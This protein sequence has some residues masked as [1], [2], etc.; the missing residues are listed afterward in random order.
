MT[1]HPI[2][3]PTACCDVTSVVRPINRISLSISSYILGPS[4]ALLLGSFCPS[5]WCQASQLIISSFVHARSSRDSLSIAKEQLLHILTHHQAMPEFIDHVFTFCRRETPHLQT[6]FSVDDHLG[7][8]QPT[9]RIDELGRSGLLAQHCFNLVGIEKETSKDPNWPYFLRQTA[10]YQ[11]FD[12]IGG[13][14]FW[15]I[16]K[17]NQ[18][19]RDRI[20]KEAD[21]RKRRHCRGK[22]E[23]AEV[24]LSMSL[25]THLLMF[26]WCAE[27]W[28]SYIDFVQS[29]TQRLAAHTMLSPVAEGTKE[30]VIASTLHSRQ[31]S[32]FSV[33][34]RASRSTS[35]GEKI[36]LSPS[37]KSSPVLP[38]WESTLTAALE[39]K[40]KATEMK[41][42]NLD[43]M[44]SFDQLQS[45][46]HHAER[47]E[48]AGLVISQNRRVIRGIVSRFEELKKS[49]TLRMHLQTEEVNFEGFIRGANACLRELDNQ[50]DRLQI[51][52][53][54]LDKVMAL[55]SC[56]AL[57]VGRERS[58]NL[59]LLVQRYTSVQEYANWAGLR[60]AS[61]RVDVHDGATQLQ[62]AR[63]RCADQARHDFNARH[64]NNDAFLPPWHVCCCK[65]RPAPP[66]LLTVVGTD[67]RPD[68]FQYRHSEF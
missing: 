15:I 54:G 5:F 60:Q 4:Y 56:T 16:L 43:K 58:T 52:L 66:T 46:H 39:N 17:G 37:P 18:A 40:P 23:T 50:Y 24:S 8:Y 51:M 29:K 61:E 41:D 6:A 65:L 20:Q 27:N 7:L 42:L 9:L 14:T 55:V 36:R 1:L 19:I 10:A 32:G 25:S 13:Q 22:L 63:Y 67:R 47:L 59:H 31:N 49:A 33:H 38:S 53:T 35:F 11:S 2:L 45:L 44:F 34:S 3:W 30:E 68:I 21:G 48:E 12:L 64:H 26:R 62:D 28:S 57:R